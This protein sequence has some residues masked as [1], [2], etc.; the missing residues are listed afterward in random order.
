ME[1][2]L[3]CQELTLNKI[4]VDSEGMIKAPDNPGTG[5]EINIQAVK[6]YLV[7]VEINVEGKSLYNTPVL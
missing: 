2:K 4:E 7:H 5:I 3:L 6:K 1:P